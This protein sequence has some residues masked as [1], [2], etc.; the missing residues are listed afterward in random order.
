MLTQ[1]VTTVI[2]GIFLAVATVANDAAWLPLAV[3]QALAQVLATPF[4]AMIA[5][6]LYF[7]LRIRKEGFD[8]ALMAQELKRDPGG[9]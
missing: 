6:L 9:A 1:I 2:V 8:L 5:V 3:G 7:D 4:S